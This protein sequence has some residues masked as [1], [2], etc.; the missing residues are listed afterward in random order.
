[1]YGSES[2]SSDESDEEQNT[3]SH[4]QSKQNSDEAI[5]VNNTFTLFQLVDFIF[6]HQSSIEL[7]I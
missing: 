6:D 2:E 4:K 1:V 3:L 7:F 5:Q